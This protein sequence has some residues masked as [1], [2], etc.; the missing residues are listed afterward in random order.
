MDLDHRYFGE[1]I[2][3]PD[4]LDDIQRHLEAQVAAR[5]RSSLSHLQ[6]RR[7][8]A[9]GSTIP[10]YSAARGEW[11]DFHVVSEIE[12]TPE[13]IASYLERLIAP[14]EVAY[15]R[16]I[17]R[18][19]LGIDDPE[20]NA[21]ALAELARVEPEI[22]TALLELRIGRAQRLFRRAW[23]PRRK[24]NTSPTLADYE[25]LLEEL[26]RIA[27]AYQLRMIAA[28]CARQIHAPYRWDML[29]QLERSAATGTLR[30]GTLVKAMRKEIALAEKA[31][32]LFK[33]S[34]RRRV[35]HGV[36]ACSP[37]ALEKGPHISF[38]QVGLQI[39]H[40]KCAEFE[41]RGLADRA[42]VQLA[43]W[44]REHGDDLEPLLAATI[45]SMRLH[46]KQ[47]KRSLDARCRPNKSNA[48]AGNDGRTPAAVRL[49]F[50]VEQA[51]AWTAEPVSHADEE[52]TDFY[53][54]VSRPV[55]RSAIAAALA[56][57]Q[58]GSSNN[59]DMPK[60][61]LQHEH[62]FCVSVLF[63]VFRFAF[64]QDNEMLP[65]K[66]RVVKDPVSGQM[67]EAKTHDR[68]QQI[69]GR[70]YSFRK[71]WLTWERERRTRARLPADT[72]AEKRSVALQITYG[73]KAAASA[74]RKRPSRQIPKDAHRA[75]TMLDAAVRRG[76]LT[77]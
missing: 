76:M 26:A 39:D 40:Q 43:L 59:S 67:K 70:P 46:L 44:Q 23:W 25:I 7:L 18:D 51:V 55:R 5:R 72:T 52:Q 24:N 49:H 64:L 65:R 4:R 73:P 57:Q 38:A 35:D 74:L 10:V 28:D 11:P 15:A 50:A 47:L 31:F 29:D 33:K 3:C 61:R 14:D 53:T 54:A 66:L 48:I 13:A 58:T 27:I 56:W 21:A 41:G 34:R 36:L 19:Y 37:L 12:R 69:T 68:V 2:A 9:G 63:T 17:I 60:P 62:A 42:R 1:F 22:V 75:M 16:S 6:R 20:A 45:Q 8:M 30:I 77:R 32:A 71:L